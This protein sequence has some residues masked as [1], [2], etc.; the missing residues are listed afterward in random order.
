VNER[1]VIT[2]TLTIR[3]WNCGGEEEIV[4]SLEDSAV[5]FNIDKLCPRCRSG[6]M[7]KKELTMKHVSCEMER[8]RH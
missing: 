2:A 5:D 7:V 3:C 4:R 6:W 8:S 1:Y